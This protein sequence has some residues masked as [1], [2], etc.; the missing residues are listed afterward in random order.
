MYSQANVRAGK[1]LRPPIRAFPSVIVD[2][3][4]VL[5]EADGPM[6][7][8][9][10]RPAMRDGWNGVR[11]R[12]RLESRTVMSCE[13]PEE[14]KHYEYF[15]VTGA[16]DSV[17]NYADLFTIGLG[18]DDVQEFDSKWNGILSSMTKIPPDDILEGLYKLR[19][20]EFEKLKTVLELY[21]LEIH[22]KKIGPD[23]NSKKKY[24]A[25]YTK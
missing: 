3:E 12:M 14:H 21:D 15:R 25:G 17:E 2:T 10:P 18:N 4:K 1:W 20:R 19:I 9:V 24:R 11:P 22:Q 23:Y 7:R 6:K 5:R 13:E 16:N 8:A